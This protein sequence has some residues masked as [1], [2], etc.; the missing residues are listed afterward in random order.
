MTVW[1]P[2]QT[3]PRPI[4]G[5]RTTNF[6]DPPP[7]A[8][9]QGIVAM[10]FAA[11]WGPLGAA[12]VLD[13]L[14]DVDDT[15]GSTA[16]TNAAREALRG[17]ARQVLGMRVGAGGTKASRT[18]Q[19]NAAANVGTATAKHAGLRGNDLRLTL[20]TSLT[21]ATKKEALI[22]ELV[23]G[24]LTL[25]QTIVFAKAGGDEMQALV[26]ATAALG[27]SPWVDFAKTAVGSGVLAD[28]N[29]VALNTVAGV[30]PVVT[31][32]DY[33]AA[34][35]VVELLDWN[36]IV[37]ATND[38]TIHATAA[39]YIDRIRN[40]GKRR[41]LILG[42]PTSIA[43]AT[44][45][46]NARAFNHPGIRYVG[47][48]GAGSDGVA[49]E[50]YL[51]AARYAGK[52]VA[53]PVTQSLTHA[54]V[55]GWTSIVGPMSVSDLEASLNAGMVVFTMSLR[56][57]VQVE[58]DLTTFVT[59]TATLD[60]GWR[61]GRRQ[62]ER[63]DLL[64]RIF[65]GWEPLLGQVNNTP[66]GRAQLIALAQGVV[67]EMIREGALLSGRVYED[68]ARP[69]A[70]DAAYFVSEVD[71]V[72]SVAKLLLTAAFRFAPPAA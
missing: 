24:A 26:D 43:L 63:D 36:A 21:D 11:S 25:R 20:R 60:A 68:P 12:S 16:A 14:G 35:A 65:A 1:T 48:G 46:A 40:E 13:S 23:S 38:T 19:D 50:G 3:F 39:A 47:N 32:A 72:D 28:L 9:V 54:V 62:R 56:K 2:G 57:Q 18:L 5:I 71:D 44:R 69:P 29:Q 45:Q 34:L 49:K 7:A 66:D 41:M 59:P 64:N 30:D 22:Y 15:F 55:E 52:V 10:L 4:V 27:G 53:S 51:A 42:E 37:L 6:G 17:G 70:G 61:Y 67:N 58:Y 8:T 33:T 31:G